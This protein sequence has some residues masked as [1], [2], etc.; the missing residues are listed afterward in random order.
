MSTRRS[1]SIVIWNEVLDFLSFPPLFPFY[2]SCLCF[3]HLFGTRLIFRRYSLNHHVGKGIPNGNC[4]VSSLPLDLSSH[5]IFPPPTSWS[6]FPNPLS[7]RFLSPPFRILLCRLCRLTRNS[8]A[9][10]QTSLFALIQSLENNLLKDNMAAD[11]VRARYQIDKGDT[12]NLHHVLAIG[13][14]RGVSQL[15]SL[16]SWSPA[17]YVPLQG[18]LR[19]SHNFSEVVISDFNS[20]VYDIIES[21]MDKILVIGSAPEMIIRQFGSTLLED[22]KEICNPTAWSRIIPS[23]RLY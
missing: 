21:I 18:Q 11:D 8:P 4:F 3:C 14:F 17:D 19:L 2:F 12:E 16:I 15:T 22:S 13:T 10:Y 9:G 23:P 20:S 5:I 7:S 1:S 6:Y